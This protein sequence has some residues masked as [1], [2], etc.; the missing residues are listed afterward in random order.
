MSLTQGAWTVKT[1]NNRLVMECDVTATTSENDIYTLKTPTELDGSRPWILMV[2]TAEADI[3]DNTDPVDIWAGFADNFAIT[4]DGAS[5]AATNGAE[6]ASAVMDDVSDEVLVTTVNPN[7]TAAKVQSVT[8]TAGEVNAGV[9]PYYAINVD[10]GSTVK[11]ATTHF[12]I[13][14]DRVRS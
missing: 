6:V 10:S 14:Q 13:I 7:R 12:V 1:V 3:S 8:D 4:G 2:N 11:A 5:V 9:A